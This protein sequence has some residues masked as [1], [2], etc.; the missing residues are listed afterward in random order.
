MNLHLEKAKE[1]SYEDYYKIR[2]EKINLFWTGYNSAPDYQKFKKWFC[3]RLKDSFRSIYLLYIDD[4]CAGALHVDQGDEAVFI[5]YSVKHEF[6]NRG[7]ATFMVEKAIGLSKKINK[8]K[9]MAWVNNEN[10]ASRKVLEKFGFLCI[11]KEKR[12]WHNEVKT[13]LLYSLN[14]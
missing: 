5:G 7:L 11:D 10:I 13:Y 9:I 1:S 4:H 2:E 3:E 6:Q 8:K 14:T 12:K